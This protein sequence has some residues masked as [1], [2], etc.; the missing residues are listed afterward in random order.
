MYQ[1]NPNQDILFR[2]IKILKLGENV[3]VDYNHALYY[4]RKDSRFET[5]DKFKQIKKGY[6]IDDIEGLNNNLLLF[7]A[8]NKNVYLLNL[9]F[10]NNSVQASNL[11]DK[12]ASILIKGKDAFYYTSGGVL[13][14]VSFDGVAT[15]ISTLPSSLHLKNHSYEIFTQEEL[16]EYLLEILRE[17]NESLDFENVSGIKK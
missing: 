16:K 14:S 2:S 5:F 11:C 4:L 6:W 17:Q 7:R 3:V 10:E 1:I 15:N 9:D 12:E 13:Y 8:T